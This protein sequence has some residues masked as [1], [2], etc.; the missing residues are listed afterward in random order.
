MTCVALHRKF[1]ILLLI[2]FSSIIFLEHQY[3]VHNVYITNYKEKMYEDN[4]YDNIYED[5]NNT[6]KMNQDNEE[7]ELIEFSIFQVGHHKCGTSSIFRFFQKNGIASIHDSLFN[8]KKKNITL[9][10]IMNNNL[11]NNKFLLSTL[12][13][14]YRFYS[15]YGTHSRNDHI[16]WY[17]IISNQY[18]NSKFI[19]LIRNVNHWLRSRYCHYSPPPIDSFII[20][21]LKKP[22]YHNSLIFKNKSDIEKEIFILNEWKHEWYEY[23]CKLLKYFNHNNLNK[24][25]LIYNIEYDSMDKIIE[26]YEKY[27]LKLNIVNV[28]K[29]ETRQKN[30]RIEQLYKWNNITKEYKQFDCKQT[31]TPFNNEYLRIAQYCHVTYDKINGFYYQ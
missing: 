8:G 4:I 29:D 14:K 19:L 2:I 23:I 30:N 3:K 7:F 1:W 12:D 24:N 15:D 6:E 21:K 18:P 22:K 11:N 5:N 17:K 13:K 31:E 20:D 16:E 28:N 27:N 25:L 26:F 9:N 10:T